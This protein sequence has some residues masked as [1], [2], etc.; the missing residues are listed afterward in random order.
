[1][2]EGNIPGA[3]KKTVIIY[4]FPEYVNQSETKLSEFSRDLNKEE[5]KIRKNDVTLQWYEVTLQ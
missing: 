5:F 1:M 2:T 4:I 3:D